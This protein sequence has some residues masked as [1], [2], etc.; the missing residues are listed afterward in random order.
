MVNM[1]KESKISWKE[2]STLENC[3][4]KNL[5][6]FNRKNGSHMYIQGLTTSISAAF[7]WLEMT[8]LLTNLG[9]QAKHQCQ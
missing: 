2:F 3:N 5:V 6:I 7:P 9:V 8:K 1:E 4:N